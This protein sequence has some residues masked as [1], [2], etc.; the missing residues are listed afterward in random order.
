MK[1]EGE[2]AARSIALG[3][4]IPFVLCI[5][6]LIG[7]WIGSWLDKTFS[8]AP[9]LSAFFLVIGMISGIREVWR[10]VKRIKKEQDD[11]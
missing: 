2:K 5:P 1:E 11:E 7:W 10:I 3:V 6:P 4:T 8:T 9:I